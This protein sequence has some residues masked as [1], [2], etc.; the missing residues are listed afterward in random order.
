MFRNTY[1][2][3][4]DDLVGL[5]LHLSQAESANRIRTIERFGL[6][7][8]CCLAT[9]GGDVIQVQVLL[10]GQVLLLQGLVQ[11]VRVIPDLQEEEVI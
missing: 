6:L 5:L 9:G 7:I 10:T 1:P 4:S 11:Y 8:G 3:I 2:F